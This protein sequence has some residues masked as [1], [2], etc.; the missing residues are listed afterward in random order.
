MGGAGSPR[1]LVSNSKHR[2][3]S[4]EGFPH[5]DKLPPV[6]SSLLAS[7]RVL[8]LSRLFVFSAPRPRGWGGGQCSVRC[9]WLWVD[10]QG[11][12]RDCGEQGQQVLEA[13]PPHLLGRACLGSLRWQVACSGRSQRPPARSGGS[14]GPPRRVV[15]DLF[16]TPRARGPRVGV[17]WA[18]L[19]GRPLIT[20]ASQGN[21]PRVRCPWA[22]GPSGVSPALC[23]PAGLQA[24]LPARAPSEGR[25]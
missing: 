10:G 16:R 12:T 24:P 11:R 22:R 9:V 4:T 19:G 17:G 14:H 3:N 15:P 13:P 7:D 2:F 5:P 21:E 23:P 18:W 8:F 25:F 6:S 1:A 20:Q